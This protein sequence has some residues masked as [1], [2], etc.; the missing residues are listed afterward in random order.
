LNPE[1][2][3][4][5]KSL[6]LPMPFVVRFFLVVSRLASKGFALSMMFSTFFVATVTGFLLS[7]SVSV[8]VGMVDKWVDG[9]GIPVGFFSE[10]VNCIIVLVL[11]L[12]FRSDF[13]NFS[14]NLMQF[15]TMESWRNRTPESRVKT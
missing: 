15:F 8:C 11:A 10:V 5:N 7:F 2:E 6:T 1:N 9:S 14:D 12:G 13:E 4:P 3:M